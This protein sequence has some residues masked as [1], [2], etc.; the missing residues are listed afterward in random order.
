MRGDNSVYNIQKAPA[1]PHFSKELWDHSAFLIQE[2]NTGQQISQEV[3]V[4]ETN[5][6][7]AH[8]ILVER[9]DFFACNMYHLDS[10]FP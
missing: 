8:V 4:V 10:F 2:H 6:I 3:E 5:D 7:S 1:L 9:G